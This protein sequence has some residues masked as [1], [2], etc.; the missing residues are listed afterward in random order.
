MSIKYFERTLKNGKEF[1]D[2]ACYDYYSLAKQAVIEY[3]TIFKENAASE[4]EITK[5]VNEILDVD[6]TVVATRNIKLKILNR[7]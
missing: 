1:A 7:F 4:E 2:R 6:F 5:V 3:Y